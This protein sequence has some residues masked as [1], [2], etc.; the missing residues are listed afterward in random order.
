MRAWVVL[1]LLFIGQ[2]DV[3]VHGDA[4]FLTF[5][6]WIGLLRPDGSVLRDGSTLLSYRELS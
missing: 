4:F 1:F 3:H 6:A 5:W 2:Q